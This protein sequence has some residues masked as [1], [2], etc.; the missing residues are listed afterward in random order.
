MHPTEVSKGAVCE[1]VEDL[2][3]RVAL[4]KERLAKQ[5]YSVRLAH[6]C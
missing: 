3:A 1:K 5:N 2:S 6:Y 4:I